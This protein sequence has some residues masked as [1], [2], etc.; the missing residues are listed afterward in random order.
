MRTKKGNVFAVSRF[1]S[2]VQ[3]PLPVLQKLMKKMP[4]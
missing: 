1:I 4:G 3:L 2:D